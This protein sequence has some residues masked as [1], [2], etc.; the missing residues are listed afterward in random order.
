MESKC[1]NCEWRK[2]SEEKPKTFSA[3]LWR[4]HL[5]FCPMWK[6]YQKELAQQTGSTGP[7]AR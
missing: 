3:R 7:A 4:F 1:A 5:K 2:R 6:A